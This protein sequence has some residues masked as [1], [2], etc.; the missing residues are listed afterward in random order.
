MA[1]RLTISTLNDDTGVLATQNGM[2]GIAK[3]W[4]C[5]NASTQTIR[6]SFNISSVTYNSGGQYTINFTTAMTDTNYVIT[7]TGREVSG[8]SS[9][10]F[11][12]LSGGSKTTSAVAVI[13]YNSPNF[14]ISP[15][16]TEVNAV[17]FR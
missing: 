7:G 10:S 2:S 13:I 16:P 5:Y 3:A 15:N 12:M 14:V 11:G 8:A 6:A 17:V 9:G 1:G 4:L